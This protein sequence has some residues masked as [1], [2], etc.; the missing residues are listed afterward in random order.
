M[1]L[2]LLPLLSLITYNF[3]DKHP[4][5]TGK[6][7]VNDLKINGI[8]VAVK[9]VKDSVLTTVYFDWQ[10][11]LALMFNHYD[12]RYIG[13]YYFDGNTDSISVK[14]R[15]PGDFDAPFAGKFVPADKAGTFHFSG[16]LGK[17][18]IDMQLERV[19]EP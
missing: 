12:S 7:Q 10:D 17:D 8:P 1:G 4:Q 13:T 11:D 16:I 19:P 9:S 3:P 2:V 5:F 18:S 6:Y 15:F 14:W